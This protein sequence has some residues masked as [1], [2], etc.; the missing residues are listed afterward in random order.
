MT[1][2]KICGMQRE[3]D[4][5]AAN[6][7]NPDFVGF[8]FADFDRHYITEAKARSFKKLLLPT[9]KAVGAFVNAPVNEVIRLLNDDV[10]NIA[11]LHGN[12]DE[13]YIS[14][15]MKETGKPVINATGVKMPTD[16]DKVRNSCAD[17]ILLDA[18][19]GCTGTAFDWSLIK[20]INRPYFLAG[21]INLLNIQTAVRDFQP[22]SI[23]LSTGAETDGQKDPE[24]MQKLVSLVREAS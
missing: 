16:I 9:I 18:P 22:Y 14:R 24:K 17:F 23:D 12:E 1:K 15:V 2:I 20:D 21:G 11:Q 7:A 13:A 8:I 5:L 19:G 6:Q 3:Q 10:I 4:I